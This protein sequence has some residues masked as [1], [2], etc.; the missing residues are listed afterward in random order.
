ME[1]AIFKNSNSFSI[2]DEIDFK[3]ES[4]DIRNRKEIEKLNDSFNVR[5]VEMSNRIS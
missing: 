1:H 3:I 4:F 5:S 2:F